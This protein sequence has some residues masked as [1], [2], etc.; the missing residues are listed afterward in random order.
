MTAN[1]NN[2]CS[3]V[4]LRGGG[5]LASGV[6]LRLHNVGI[7]IVIIELQRP[8]AV[9]RRV[10]FSE[11][12]YEGQVVVEG[13]TAE[14]VNHFSEIEQVIKSGKIPV[15]IDPD[16]EILE[17]SNFDIPVIVDARMRKRPPES[18]LEQASLVIGLGPG[19]IAGENC[20][21]VIET[22]R[23]HYLG[24]VI[25]EGQAEENTGTPGKI[26]ERGYDRVLRAP[27]SGRLITMVDIGTVLQQGDAICAVEGDTIPAPFNGVLRGLL[28]NGH[29]VQK[30]MK[31]GD[32]D[33]RMNPRLAKTISEK[34]FAIGG[35]VLEALLTRPEIREKLWN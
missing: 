27:A 25:W 24:R 33:P 13:V 30:G 29:P 32:L 17:I 12:V 34:S 14:R 19:F 5:D 23:G 22:N 26:G 9:R 7:N 4:L 2:K 31:I 21:A 1:A 10:S 6:A 11:S 8:L 20:H 18:G 15:S 16:L 28:R 3:F 35:G